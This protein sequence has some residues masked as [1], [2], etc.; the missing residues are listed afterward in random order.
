MRRFFC[1]GMGEMEVWA[2]RVVQ[3]A[4]ARRGRRVVL[5]R[6]ARSLTVAALKIVLVYEGDFVDLL[7]CRHSGTDFVYGR[8][9]QE[10][11]ALLFGRALDF[12]G[13][14]LVQNQFADL[15]GQIEQLMNRRSTAI[16]CASQS[17]QPRPS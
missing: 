12:T 6:K 8:L 5:G 13:W 16:T 3:R 11:H 14:T 10:G 15:F 2:V 1:G 17:K 9:T 7:Q 4:S